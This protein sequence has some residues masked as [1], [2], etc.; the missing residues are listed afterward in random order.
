MLAFATRAMLF[1]DLLVTWHLLLLH[2]ERQI[3]EKKTCEPR[4][5]TDDED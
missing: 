4:P 3:S 5:T 1:S 2:R